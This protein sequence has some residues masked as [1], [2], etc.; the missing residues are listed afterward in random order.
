MNNFIE[1][2]HEIEGGL[3]T[4][5]GLPAPVI[6]DYLSRENSKANYAEGVTFQIGRI[7]MIANTGTYLDVPFHR[8]PE[9]FDLSELSLRL[10]ANLPGVVV[11]CSDFDRAI[12]SE[13]FKDI[14]VRGAAILFH[15]G[16]DKHWRTPEYRGDNPF[17]TQ[18]GCERLIDHGAVL[19]GIDSI[20]IDDLKDISRPAHSLLLKAGIP[21][22]EHLCNLQSLPDAGFRFFAIPPKIKKF[23]S[24]PVRAF[25]LLP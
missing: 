15:T 4:Y 25:A 5:P 10:I 13:L 23:G 20:N 19:V 2:S 16:W 21:I 12:T 24:F 1:L 11:R 22:V 9:G 6:S 17:L 7:E 14:D 3:I 8:Y 18:A